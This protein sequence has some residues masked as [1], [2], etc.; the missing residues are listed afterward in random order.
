LAWKGPGLRQRRTTKSAT[1]LSGDR[2]SSSD[3]TEFG[4]KKALF[5][6]AIVAI[7]VL[8]ALG[9]D[10][11]RELRTERLLADEA[12]VALRTEVDQNRVRLITK[13]AMLHRS[14][15]VLANDPTLAPTLVQQRSN[16]QITLV[17]AAWTL[18]LQTGALRLLEPAERQSFASIYTSQEVYNQLLTEEMNRWTALAA[19]TGDASAVT[20]WRAY[21]LRVALGDCIVSIRIERFRNPRL[22]SSRLQRACEAYRPSVP[23]ETLYRAFGVPMPNTRWRPGGEF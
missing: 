7:G 21:A 17:N 22:P 6:I 16:I 20:V 5:E 12:R 10:E 18:A 23:P 4:L 11:I 2:G 15:Q 3:L 1:A 8:L 9:V 19:P 13:L 14:D